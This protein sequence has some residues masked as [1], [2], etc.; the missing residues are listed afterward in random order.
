MKT[1]VAITLAL[2]STTA[3]AQS[4]AEDK[5]QQNKLIGAIAGGYLGSTIGGGD[6][7][8]AATVLGAVLGYKFG[9]KILED[10]SHKVYN[11][12]SKY[13]GYYQPRYR[14][15][16]IYKL[17]DHRNPYHKDSRMYW[18][19]NRGCV[20]RLSEQVR[21]LEQDAYEQGYQGN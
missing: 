12:D 20:Q 19:Y 9:D 14:Q 18:S 21:Q 6:G 7:K 13:Y 17:C 16:D 15:A 2:L 11:H 1:L 10:N 5:E 8:T 3:Y 4:Y